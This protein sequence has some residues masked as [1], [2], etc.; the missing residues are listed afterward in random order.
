MRE[1]YWR[2]AAAGRGRCVTFP[3]SLGLD[4]RSTVREREKR[5]FQRSLS[6][7]R[8]A[9]DAGEERRDAERV[10]SERLQMQRSSLEVG[11]AADGGRGARA[12]ERGSQAILLCENV[13][14]RGALFGVVVAA[15]D[16]VGLD[17][18]EE[19]ED[20]RSGGLVYFYGSAPR[21]YFPRSFSSLPLHSFDPLVHSPSRRPVRPPPPP[22]PIPHSMF[23]HCTCET[24]WIQRQIHF[25]ARS[26][27]DGGKSYF[28]VKTSVRRSSV[29][30]SLLHFSS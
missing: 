16:G 15:L 12:V 27:F 23:T 13:P 30:Q 26:L 20:L 8:S 7:Q 19:E 28:G 24:Q 5:A 22:L 29:S 1:F 10:N 2:C 14:K 18:E 11:A 21:S 17:E 4:S 3:R 6:P 9:I 25:R